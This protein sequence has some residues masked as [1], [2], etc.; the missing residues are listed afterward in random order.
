MNNPPITEEEKAAALALLEGNTYYGNYW[1]E[2]WGGGNLVLVDGQFTICELEAI[3]LLK[4]YQLQ[5]QGS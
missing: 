2:N 5:Q 1:D 3:I 4:R